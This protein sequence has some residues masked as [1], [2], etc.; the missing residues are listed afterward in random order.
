VVAHGHCTGRLSSDED[1]LGVTTEDM[2]IFLD[3]VESQP[4]IPEVEIG[5]SS[6]TPDFTGTQETTS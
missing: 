6:S 2:D 1:F 5:V 4:L 3:P